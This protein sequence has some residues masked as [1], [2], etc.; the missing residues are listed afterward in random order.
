MVCFEEARLEQQRECKRRERLNGMYLQHTLKP[1][2][3][4]EP[5][6]SGETTALSTLDG[7]SR[8]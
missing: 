8:A 4:P 2:A 3:V 5:P 6:L 1:T 7:Q